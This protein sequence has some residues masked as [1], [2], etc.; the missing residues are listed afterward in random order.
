MSRACSSRASCSVV[1]AAS[2]TA[3][4]FEASAA[5]AFGATV[6]CADCGLPPALAVEGFGVVATRAAV[7][8]VAAL[9][10]GA[11]GGWTAAGACAAR[12]ATGGGVS[13]A[14]TVP[15][16]RTETVL[17]FLGSIKSAMLWGSFDGR[18]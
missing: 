2:W 12:G 4:V 7:L 17:T 6:V 10:A 16:G 9:A 1:G 13:F 18:A 3:N 14:T 15:S 8:G 11:A 5:L